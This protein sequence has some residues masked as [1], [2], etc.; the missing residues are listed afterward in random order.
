MYDPT[1]LEGE[2]VMISESDY[3]IVK[4]IVDDYYQNM[5]NEA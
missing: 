5:K 1:M 3:S 4:I 2:K